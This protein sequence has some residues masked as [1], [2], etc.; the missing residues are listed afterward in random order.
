MVNSIADASGVAFG[1]QGIRGAVDLANI[2]NGAPTITFDTTVFAG[3]QTIKLVAG[4]LEFSQANSNTTI[5]GPA[6]GVTISGGGA[7]RIFQLDGL[8][9]ANISNLTITGGGGTADRGGGVLVLGAATLNLTNSTVT[10][11]T[12]STNGGGIANYGTA[13][14]MNCTVGGNTAAMNG[15]GVFGAAATTTL[16]N[17]TVS[18]NTAGQNGGGVFSSGS[19]GVTNLG[20]S[21]IVGNTA[22]SGG[23]VMNMGGV[24]NLINCTFATDTVS[25]D[26]GGVANL[27]GGLAT[28]TDCTFSN[29]TAGS[30]GGGMFNAGTATLTNTIVAGNTSSTSK[31]A[32]D[33]GGT[34]N[35][36]GT[37]NLIGTGGSGGLTIG[38]NGNI[39]GVA[40]PGL[41]GLANY[42]GPTL[43]MALL[44][45]SPAIGK[46]TA[47]N[48]VTTDQRGLIRGKIVDIG[49]FQTTLVVESTGGGVDTTPAQLTLAG[50]VSL[51]NQ[52]TGPVVVS[53]DPAVF[54]GG[55]TIA[56]AAPLVLNNLGTIPTWTI[57]GPANG[58]TISGG[59]YRVFQV[60][61]TVTATLSGLTIMSN[62]AGNGAGLEDFGTANVSTSKFLA[63]L[64]NS[65]GAIYVVGGTLSVVTS[66]ISGWS[67][68]VSVGLTSSAAINNDTITGNS[69]GI[70]VGSKT[71]DNSTVTATVDDFSG[72]KVG[73]LNVESTPVA[74]TLNWWGSSFGP[75]TAGAASTSG[76]VSFSPWLADT[77]SLTLS[78][79]DALGFTSN[80]ANSYVVTP[81]TKGPNLG[82]FLNGSRNPNW[83]VTP[84]GTLLFSGSGGALTI[85][86]ESG[87]GFN[88]NAF[89]LNTA[90]TTGPTI[91][92]AAND[93]FNGATVILSGGVV[94]TVAAQGMTNTFNVSAWT[95]A[96]ALVGSPAASAVSTVLATKTVSPGQTGGLTLTSS[97]F[98]SADG[99]NLN[100]SGLSAA[101]LT[102]LTTDV[103][104]PTVV[105]DASGFSGTTNL[106]VGGPAKLVVFGGGT[107]GKGGNSLTLNNTATANDVL[108]GGPGGNTLLDNGTG[109]DILIGGGGKGFGGPNVLTGNGKDILISGYTRQPYGSW[110]KRVKRSQRIPSSVAPR[111]VA[112]CLLLGWHR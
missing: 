57:T 10:G 68:G 70:V 66:T 72:N 5:T 102:V 104:Q 84:T 75:N 32:S 85:N 86:G 74:A 79:P 71:G 42:G 3:P 60:N 14:L 4:M 93:A 6:K 36:S 69:G 107:A 15:G 112:F 29:E 30:S 80:A 99:M 50:A 64:P 77:A 76:N 91:T 9:T 28:V 51:A 54:T 7:S 1:K 88:T 63:S 12:G 31:T 109:D 67:T 96:G 61:K 87:A 34:S 105:V 44:A 82:I 23:G 65:G 40:S 33:I 2:L 49:A 17:S 83:L 18:G 55:Q 90:G 56:L 20:S 52:F 22:V 24:L 25:T 47:V 62:Y 98:K 21:T 19:S 111:L 73:V 53:F 11:N 39:V 37:N 95:G 58:V 106:T 8:V 94:P 101:T 100:V 27:A 46:G 43:T 103:R 48:G 26:G 110:L 59:I 81:V 16:I 35:V 38:Q 13:N 89:V 92:Y 97:S 45:G 78:P 41:G 108:I